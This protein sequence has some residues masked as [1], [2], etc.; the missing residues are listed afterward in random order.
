[1]RALALLVA[2]LACSGASAELILQPGSSPQSQERGRFFAPLR[3]LVT[4]GRGDPIPNAQVSW[5]KPVTSG[6]LVADAS[7]YCD[8]DPLGSCRVQADAQGLATLPLMYGPV[9]G[10]YTLT[11]RGGNPQTQVKAFFTVTPLTNAPTIEVGGGAGQVVR[12]GETAQPIV[13]LVRDAAGNPLRGIDVGFQI[14]VYEGQWAPPD[15]FE[16]TRQ[17]DINGNAT[18]PSLIP[19]KGLGVMRGS[20]TITAP[21]TRASIT[22]PFTY[23]VVAPDGS[24]F[25]PLQEMWWNPAENGWGM[26]VNQNADRLFTVVYAY[27]ANG[28][29]TWYVVPDG[30]WTPG[31]R[32]RNYAGAAYSPRGSPYFAYDASRFSAGAP[33]A[34]GAI[35][36]FRDRNLYPDD[37]PT[38]F[39]RLNLAAKMIVRQ[40]FG[41]DVP[42]R[43][44]GIAGMWW[45]GASQNGWGVSIIQQ[46]GGTFAVWFTYDADGAPTWFVMP[47]GAWENDT[48]YSGTLYKTHGSAWLIATY[49]PSRLV[50]TPVGTFRFRFFDVNSA[51]FE[52]T[53]EGRAGS[54]SIVRL[55]F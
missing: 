47:T 29:P 11:F 7:T 9:E 20:A 22:V 1:M 25:L 6:I 36:N 10:S 37:E 26:S 41:P 18:S 2:F 45:G 19:S 39:L 27:D 46:P 23:T 53:A 40:D 48:T 42:P 3:I 49:D 12:V 17:T 50:V 38:S 28:N 34:G 14:N 51:A 5:S 31:G 32:F 13:A 52:W 35:L 54:S 44:Q 21:G 24:D 30:A 8:F 43:M 15:F 16:A 55:P 4:D 33:I